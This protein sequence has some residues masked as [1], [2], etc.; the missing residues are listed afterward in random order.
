MLGVELG[1]IEE[2]YMNLILENE[3]T[4][5][6]SPFIS[7]RIMISFQVQQYTRRDEKPLLVQYKIYIY[8]VSD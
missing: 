3:N 8:L 7:Y 5:N 1:V 2:I 4:E 6:G